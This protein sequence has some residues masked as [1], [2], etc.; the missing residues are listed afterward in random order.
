MKARQSEGWRFK[1]L[2]TGD[3]LRKTGPSGVFMS[4][5]KTKLGVAT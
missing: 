3:S 1:L 5:V 2:T 4:E